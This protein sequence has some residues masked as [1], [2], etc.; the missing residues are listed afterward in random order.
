MNQI[1]NNKVEIENTVDFDE[2]QSAQVKRFKTSQIIFFGKMTWK[3]RLASIIAFLI[4]KFTTDFIWRT[5]LGIYFIATSIVGTY[6]ILK[7]FYHL[8][9]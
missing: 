9:I 4:M 5:S 7:W 3:Q 8:F 6:Q 2:F 1:Q